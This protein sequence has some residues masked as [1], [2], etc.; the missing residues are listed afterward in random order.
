MYLLAVLLGTGTGAATLT[1]PA[2]AGGWA[3]TVI[4]PAGPI[5]PGKAHQVSFWVLQHGT[6]PYNWAEP[7]SM[8][9]VG[10]MLSDDRGSRISFT[11][12]PLPE[13]AHYV[14]TVTVPHAG[15]W[16]VTGIQGI[17]GG[18]HVGELTV[19]GTWQP[20]GVPAAPS[21][22]DLEKYWP[23]KVRPPVL[24]IDRQR[25]PYVNEDT[26]PEVITEPAPANAAAGGQETGTRGVA[27]T[28][29]DPLDRALA[30]GLVILLLVALALGGRWWIRRGVPRT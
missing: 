29:P 11:G 14:T 4:D 22:Q 16:K 21:P 18:F 20:L 28:Q 17:F 19:P 30:G 1:G 23:G 5:E 13:P 10:L 3:V 27:A 6:H 26:Q 24:T 12:T 2:A 9:T 7:A 25:D 15:R 8:G